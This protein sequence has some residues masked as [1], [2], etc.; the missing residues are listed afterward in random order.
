M[1]N[2]KIILLE[3]YSLI[4]DIEVNLKHLIYNRLYQ[5]RLTKKESY[6]TI[7]NLVEM[8]NLLPISSYE[9]NTLRKTCQIR[10]KICHMQSLHRDDIYVL[11]QAHQL[12]YQSHYLPKPNRIV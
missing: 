10:N 1:T 8:N 11:N 4:Y 12:I 6:W 5:H 9:Y 2:N 3:A 7:I